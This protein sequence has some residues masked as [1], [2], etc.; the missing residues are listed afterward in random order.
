MIKTLHIENFQSHKDTTVELSTLVTAFVGM[1]NHGKSAILRALKKIIRNEPDGNQFVSDWSD[2]CRLIIETDIGRVERKVRTDSSSEANIYKA[3]DLIFAKFGHT[4]IPEEVITRMRVSLPKQ[5]GDVEID[6]NFQDQLDQLFLVQGDGL[7]SLRGKVLGLVTGVDAVQRAIQLAASEE[8]RAKHQIGEYEF[9]LLDLEKRVEVYEDVDDQTETVEAILQDFETTKGDQ[10][11]LLLLE[12]TYQDLRSCVVKAKEIKSLVDILDVEFSVPD[13][14][15]DLEIIG[16]LNEVISLERDIDFIRQVSE[17]NI[18]GLDSKGLEE[19]IAEVVGAE[20]VCM[21]CKE[22]N[23]SIKQSTKEIAQF[24]GEL[25]KAEAE[26]EE[27]KVILKVCP[28][29]KRPF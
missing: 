15:S 9:K 29:C 27:I 23:E 28:T 17:L 5:F 18:D 2:E 7:P 8:K 22:C 26:L 16:D 10:E 20:L 12:E 25:H 21:Q 11:D 19:Q 6:L 4:G 3:D 13:I 1:N 14:G 24:V